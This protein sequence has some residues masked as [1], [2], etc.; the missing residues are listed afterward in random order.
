M[1]KSGAFPKG[2]KFTWDLHC[3]IQTGKVWHLRQVRLYES[4]S[5]FTEYKEFNPVEIGEKIKKGITLPNRNRPDLNDKKYWYE[6][7]Q[8]KK[9]EWIKEDNRY[10]IDDSQVVAMN[11]IININGTAQLPHNR[12]YTLNTLADLQNILID[13][14]DEIY[15]YFYTTNEQWTKLTQD[16]YN[17]NNESIWTFL[18]GCGYALGKQKGIE[19]LTKLLTGSDLKQPPI[20]KIW[21]EGESISPRL[22]EGNTHVDL[23]IGVIARR[24]GTKSGIRYDN[25][26]ATWVCFCEA[27]FS[28]DISSGVKYD[29]NR[30]Q[31]VRDIENAICFQDSGIYAENVYVTII[32]PRFYEH[33]RSELELKYKNYQSDPT[34]IKEP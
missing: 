11:Q 19:M 3:W 25:S 22:K 34:V 33:K 5:Y 9:K 4:E 20:S 7:I 17:S 8:E 6:Y 16:I 32:T 28:S 13:R 14:K 31:L 26:I 30:N 18:V 27:K 12:L 23:A 21:I 1:S 2:V 24:K 15:E 29:A 10:E